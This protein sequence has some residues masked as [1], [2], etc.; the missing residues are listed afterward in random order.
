MR[1][2][3][4][5]GNGGLNFV[6]NALGEKFDYVLDTD[7]R[8]WGTDLVPGLKIISPNEIS[9]DQVNVFIVASQMAASIVRF[10]ESAGVPSHKIR[11]APKAL[12]N[13]QPFADKENREDAG[14]CINLFSD[15]LLKNGVR[16][17]AH[18]GTALGA[19]RNRDL[20]SWDSDV[21]FVVEAT[22]TVMREI[23]DI[24][25]S[26][27][28]EFNATIESQSEGSVRVRFNS[29][30]SM[31]VINVDVWDLTQDTIAVNPIGEAM[32]QF[33]TNWFRNPQEHSWNYGVIL[34]PSNISHYLTYVYGPD[35]MHPRQDFTVLDYFGERPTS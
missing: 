9:L 15:R 25:A 35:W 3:F 18:H 31:F 2:L 17:I 7:S 23:E 8:K 29:L 11:I 34:L 12:I 10:L 27:L 28:D 32:F 13:R 14:A 1:V 6:S 19:Y 33:P 22:K 26:S 30:S 16:P 5:G 21:N 24:C 20:I 4:G